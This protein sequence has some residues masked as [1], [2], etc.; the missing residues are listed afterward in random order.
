MEKLEN[1]VIIKKVLVDRML[2]YVSDF[3]CALDSYDESSYIMFNNEYDNLKK[4]FLRIINNRL[5]AE[6]SHIKEGNLARLQELYEYHKSL[7]Y[8]NARINFDKLN[9]K[10][11]TDEAIINSGLMVLAEVENIKKIPKLVKSI[12]S[13]LDEIKIY[14]LTPS[15]N[16]LASKFKTMK[17]EGATYT[18]Y[19]NLNDSLDNIIRKTYI[20]NVSSL[21]DINQSSIISLVV[22]EDEECYELLTNENMNLFSFG[23]I[24]NPNDIVNAYN[25][26]HEE[27]FVTYSHL[28][29]DSNRIVVNGKPIGIYALTMGNKSLSKNYQNAQALV[30]KYRNLPFIEIDMTKYL[31]A[32]DLEDAKR[33][34]IDEL[35]E[36]KNAP[37]SITSRDGFYDRFDYF[38]D[39][40]KSLK[41]GKYDEGNIINLF[42]F[43]FNLTY[44]QKY[45]NLNYL[46]SDKLSVDEAKQA[47]MQNI[48][49]TE[50]IFR[51][52]TV[53][54]K[55]IERFLSKYANYFNNEM[56]NKVYPGINVIIEV[57]SNASK[58]EL[59]EIIKIINT[60]DK[61]SWLIAQK[62]RPTHQI[63]RG[64]FS[65]VESETIKYSQTDNGE[66][67]KTFLQS[68]DEDKNQR[69]RQ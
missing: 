30:S 13:K 19:A 54:E 33:E 7:T 53:D 58:E 61:D 55:M 25:D 14:D 29:K 65:S 56:L 22:S 37:L 41:G 64:E 18:D 36:N 27:R 12:S 32:K 11:Y 52:E 63:N 44:S 9:V 2:N 17:N 6:V 23:Y 50:N 68:M 10:L 51:Y 24:Y 8:E 15:V 69:R 48:Y 4:K 47:L 39:E 57:L 31:S 62:L 34:F 38:F 43:C 20:N 3:S 66:D 26:G 59:A 40:Y 49:H 21:S 46:F 28:D 1:N 60:T 45:S 5:I 16:V 67:L 42:D 35:V